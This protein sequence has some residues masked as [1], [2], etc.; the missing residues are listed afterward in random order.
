MPGHDGGGDD[1]KK[2]AIQEALERVRRKK[3]QADYAPQNTANLTPEQQQ[4][5]DAADRRRR[6]KNGQT[7]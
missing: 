5:I 7:D 2:A 4:L 3:E 1:P 6:Q